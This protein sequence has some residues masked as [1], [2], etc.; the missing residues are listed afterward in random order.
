MV[1]WGYHIRLRAGF[2]RFARRRK[3]PRSTYTAAA[4]GLWPG[5]RSLYA[6][7][8]WRRGPP[9]LSSP[10]RSTVCINFRSM[11]S[12]PR[13][14]RWRRRREPPAPRFARCRSLR[15]PPGRSTRC[16]GAGGRR[17]TPSTRPRQRYGRRTPESYQESAR[18]CAPPAK[19]TKR[20]SRPSRRRRL[21]SFATPGS[22]QPTRPN[23]RSLR[24]FAPCPPRRTHPAASPKSC[25]QPGSNCSPDFPP[26]AAVTARS[27]P[28]ASKS[29]NAAAV[30][31]PKDAART[32]ALAKAK[33]AVAAAVRAER[34]ADEKA[35]RE[36]FEAARATREAER[37]VNALAKARAGARDCPGSRRDRRAGSRGGDAQER[38]GGTARAETADAL[39]A[40]KVRT[41]AAQAALTRA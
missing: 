16:T 33:E 38:C 21:P 10:A 11:S 35:R 29:S 8:A 24:R 5:R 22:R 20:R 31:K 6:L 1:S 27:T 39:A 37:A 13:G 14:T 12:P 34:A 19:R 26:L 4:R 9:M 7:R 40:A 36:E 15:W 3:R 32:K 23:R 28:A 2:A 17:S 25:N 41:E 18:T 30:P